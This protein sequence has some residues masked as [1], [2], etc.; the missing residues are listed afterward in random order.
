MFESDY[1]NNPNHECHSADPMADSRYSQDSTPNPQ[2]SFAFTEDNVPI[3]DPR[4]LSDVATFEQ[5]YLI[6]KTETQ[7]ADWVEVLLPRA[8][9]SNRNTCK[10][11]SKIPQKDNLQ[12]QDTKMHILFLWRRFRLTK[13]KAKMFL[14]RI[15]MNGSSKITVGRVC[16]FDQRCL[17]CDI[18]I[19]HRQFI[20]TM[21]VTRLSFPLHVVSK[22]RMSA[23]LPVGRRILKVLI[24]PNKNI[25]VVCQLDPRNALTQ[26]HNLD[27]V[28]S[29]GPG[30]YFRSQPKSLILLTYLLIR[31]Q[32]KIRFCEKIELNQIDSFQYF[33]N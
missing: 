11:S 28:D 16:S 29:Q 3:V 2:V 10:S 14:L 12:S 20:G 4:H 32:L 9:I 24:S 17:L 33:L 7:D 19:P 21:Q 8:P 27:F 25:F 18:Q 30:E 22:P 13:T 1:L 31:V 23:T 6:G 5:P 26:D 15:V